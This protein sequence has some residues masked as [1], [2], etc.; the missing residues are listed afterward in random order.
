MNFGSQDGNGECR[1]LV[2]LSNSGM[3]TAGR[4]RAS[5]PF[6]VQ[7]AANASNLGAYRRKRRAEPADGSDSYRTSAA[8]LRAAPLPGSRLDYSA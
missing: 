4:H 8:R 2:P 6:V 3:E 7:L 1:A 5:A